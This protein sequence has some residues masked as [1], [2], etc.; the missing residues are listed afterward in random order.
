MVGDEVERDSRNHQLIG[1]GSALM[2]A[3]VFTAVGALALEDLA[4]GAIVGVFAGVGTLLFL[5]WFLRLS[6]IQDEASDDT[7]FS[8]AVRRAGGNAKMSVFGL[9]LELG[10][11]AML[12][13]GFALEE[14]DY[15]AGI[16]VAIAVA[17]AVPLVA[18]A[19]FGR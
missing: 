5:P 2:Y 13:V 18:T 19:L 14:P 10:A 12:A 1:S 16:G 15:L 3:V 11:I 9:G 7:P 4:Y 8:E 6:S 17:V